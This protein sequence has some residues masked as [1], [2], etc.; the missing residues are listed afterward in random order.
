MRAALDA[1]CHAAASRPKW[2]RKQPENRKEV[3][4]RQAL[5]KEGGTEACWR[6]RGKELRKGSWASEKST[7][8]GMSDLS[9]HCTAEEH[10]WL[11]LLQRCSC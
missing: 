11:L 4:G 8:D 6:E 10:G 3:D 5:R 9:T 7:D 2:H 1:A